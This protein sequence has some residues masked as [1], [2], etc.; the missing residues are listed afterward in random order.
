MRKW[1]IPVRAIKR[2][3]DANRLRA[4]LLRLAAVV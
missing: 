1:Q 3:D 4:M 2:A